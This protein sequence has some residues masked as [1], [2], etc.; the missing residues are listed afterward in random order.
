MGGAW[1]MGFPKPLYNVKMLRS[2]LGYET[3]V[4]GLGKVLH[5]VNTKKLGALANHHSGEWSVCDFLKLTSPEIYHCHVT[6]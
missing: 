3:G 5:Y 6:D 2:F 4:E 1:K